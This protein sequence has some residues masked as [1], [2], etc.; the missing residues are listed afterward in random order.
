MDIIIKPMETE[1]EMLGKGYV[2]FKSWQ[3]TYSDL[4]DAEYMRG[5]TEERCADIAR[6]WPDNILVAKDGDTVIGFVGYGAYR[7]DTLPNCGE[8][9]SIYVLGDY[10][11]EKVGFRLMNAAFE[12]LSD[13]NKIALWVLKGNDRAIK[14]Y[15]RYGFR[16]DGTE[17]EIMLGTTNTEFRMIYDRC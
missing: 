15:E 4:V 10:L 7:D 11:G 9:F 1:S 16:F 13:Y 12:R 5:I 8:I 3:E 17:Q 2:H 6:K 14:F